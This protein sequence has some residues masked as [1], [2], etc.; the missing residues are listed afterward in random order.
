MTDKDNEIRTEDVK[1]DEKTDASKILKDL[2]PK[3]D[4]KGGGMYWDED[5]YCNN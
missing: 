4:V 1:V 2:E 5:P 3:S